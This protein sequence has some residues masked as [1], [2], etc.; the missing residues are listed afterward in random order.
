[1]YIKIHYVPSNDEFSQKP[2]FHIEKGQYLEI[3]GLQYSDKPKLK[4]RL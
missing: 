1:M 2:K 4:L 3:V